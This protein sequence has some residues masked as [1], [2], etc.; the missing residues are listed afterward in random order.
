MRRASP[1]VGGLALARAWRADPQAPPWAARYRP[2][3]WAALLAGPAAH[4]WTSRDVNA[5]ITD[6]AR[7]A[8]VRAATGGTW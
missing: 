8:M 4:G 6:W 3:A 2:A 1:D 7:A 5:L